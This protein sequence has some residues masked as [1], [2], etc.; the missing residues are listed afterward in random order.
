MYYDEVEKKLVRERIQDVEPYLDYNA[1]LRSTPQ[2]S[3]WGRHVANIPNVIYEKWF[4]EYN[5]N[6]AVPDFKMFGE[7]FAAYVDKK[8]QDPAWKYL[9]VDK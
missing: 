9:R 7:E 2:K 6:R 5:A 3:D 4:N 1:H 8:L